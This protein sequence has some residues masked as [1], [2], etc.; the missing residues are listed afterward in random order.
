MRA[1]TVS[2]TGAEKP[3]VLLRPRQRHSITTVEIGVGAAILAGGKIATAAVPAL[4]QI[5]GAVSGA[6]FRSVEEVADPAFIEAYKNATATVSG[7]EEVADAAAGFRGAGAVGDEG[8]DAAVGD[9]D[10]SSPAFIEAYKNATATVSGAE[11]V[12]DAAAG[13]RGAGA[14]RD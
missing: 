6:P 8:A 5:G 13:F 4:A 10:L 3:S 12:A 2:S 7:A 14:V 1:P 11:E 9:V